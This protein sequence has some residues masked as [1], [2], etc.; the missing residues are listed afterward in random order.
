LKTTKP[1]AQFRQLIAKSNRTPQEEPMKTKQRLSNIKSAFAAA[2]LSFAAMAASAP[3]WAAPVTL[4]WSGWLT[5]TSE[6]FGAIGSEVIQTLTYD[7][8]SPLWGTAYPDYSIYKGISYSVQSGST[9][10][11]NGGGEFSIWL[12]TGDD[13]FGIPGG[14]GIYVQHRNDGGYD[15]W[16]DTG[17]VTLNGEASTLALRISLVDSSGVLLTDQSLPSSLPALPGLLANI[18]AGS[19]FSGDLLTNF[20]SGNEYMLQWDSAARPAPVPLPAPLA[21]LGLGLGGLRLVGR[22]RRGSAGRA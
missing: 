18:P 1:G 6:G 14:E 10:V 7:T 19:M 12:S 9:T 2:A 20:G 8:N 15:S 13:M 17:S 3:A 11:T 16:G 5:R 21:L 22:R 4:T